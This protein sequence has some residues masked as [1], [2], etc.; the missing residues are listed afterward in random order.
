M[1]KGAA[2]LNYTC[3]HCQQRTMACRTVQSYATG[4]LDVEPKLQIRVW[5]WVRE[6]ELRMAVF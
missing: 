4:M 2:G 5:D 3:Q 6:L 1:P